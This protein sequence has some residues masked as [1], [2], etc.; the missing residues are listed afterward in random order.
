MRRLLLTPRWIAGHLLVV[1]AVITFVNLGFWQLRR[2]DERRAYNALV[3]QRLDA[4][5]VPL[6]ELVARF[7]DDPDALEFRRVVVNGRYQPEG[8]LLTAP[9]SRDGRP[10]PQVLTVLD[11]GDGARVLVDRGWIPFD[12]AAVRAPAPPEGS[13]RVEG[14]VLGPEPGA[15]GTGE[16][17]AR[18]VP[19]QIGER[20][21]QALPAFYVELWDQRPAVPAT[22]PLPGRP[23]DLLEGSHQSYALQWFAFALIALVGYPMLLWRTVRGSHD[24]VTDRPEVPGGEP[25]RPPEIHPAGASSRPSTAGSSAERPAGEARR[26]R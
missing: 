11:A 1:L 17:V 26:R 8:Q 19:R 22:G 9:R 13:V 25:S 12:R 6:D 18:I 24:D 16:Q 4:A 5:P 2:L 23:P 20:T 14:I 3:T 7:G 10:G 21:G 15:T